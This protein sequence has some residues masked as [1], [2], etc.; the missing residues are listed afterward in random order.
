[1]AAL[2]L[3]AWLAGAAPAAAQASVPDVAL[4]TKIAGKVTYGGEG[5]ALKSAQSFMKVRQGDRFQV[6]AGEVLQLVFFA[7]GRQ[8][9]WSGPVDLVVGE[10]AGQATGAK[11]PL[12][13][14]EVVV[15]PAKA[16]KRLVDAAPLSGASLRYTGAIQTMAPQV[17]APLAKTGKPAQPLTAQAQKDLREAQ[18]TYRQMVK[19]AAADDVTPELYYLSVLAEYGQTAQMAEVAAAMA[20]KRPQ[21]AAVKSVQDWVRAQGAPRP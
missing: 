15:L 8:E 7:N 19:S 1:M 11:E 14:P 10:A 13:K 12:P 17:A 20:A 18:K 9:I 3:G 16:T 2:V 4:V 21:D 6:P 5:G